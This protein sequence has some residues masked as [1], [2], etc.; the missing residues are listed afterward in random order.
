MISGDFKKKMLDTM[1]AELDR[2]QARNYLWVGYGIVTNGEFVELNHP[3]YKRIRI[4]P[5]FTSVTF[6]IP[7]EHP[8]IEQSSAG[9]FAEDYTDEPV[10]VLEYRITLNGGDSATVE[11][12]WPP[13]S[14]KDVW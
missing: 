8:A 1:N 2:I 13:L 3:G 7:D 9:F 11:F 5:T 4:D 14:I 6:R 12:K 10:M